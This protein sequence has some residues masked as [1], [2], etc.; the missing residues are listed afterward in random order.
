MAKA[1]RNVRFNARSIKALKNQF[2]YKQIIQKVWPIEAHLLSNLS[3]K[4]PQILSFY[5]LCFKCSES[6]IWL[7]E[8]NIRINRHDVTSLFIT[9]CTKE[10]FWPIILKYIWHKNF[11]TSFCRK[12]LP[13]MA[14]LNVLY[15]LVK[16]KATISYQTN[17][18]IWSIKF[19]RG[20]T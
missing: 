17:S 16:A 19:L 4:N 15:V 2:Y 1:L 3:I 12:S 18:Y 10:G 7:S 6:R 8:P 5:S 11:N 13:I 9:F 14:F 20:H